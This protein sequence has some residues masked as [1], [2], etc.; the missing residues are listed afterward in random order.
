MHPSEVAAGHLAPPTLRESYQDAVETW[1]AVLEQ[2]APYIVQY[3]IAN[4]SVKL[5]ADLQITDEGVI[6]YDIIPVPV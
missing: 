1:K 2:R 3:L 6:T 5:L 4:G